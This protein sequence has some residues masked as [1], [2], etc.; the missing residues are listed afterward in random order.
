VRLPVRSRI[1]TSYFHS[2]PRERSLPAIAWRR[3]DA[4][5][6]AH[7]HGRQEGDRFSS[8]DVRQQRAGLCSRRPHRTATIGPASSPRQWFRSASEQE[9]QR[10]SSFE[11]LKRKPRQ[12]IALSVRSETV[13]VTDRDRVSTRPRGR[14][15]SDPGRACSPI[16]S[17]TVAC[18]GRSRGPS[19]ACAGTPTEA[20]LGSARRAASHP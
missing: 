20:I 14:P 4:C 1:N 11:A 5:A 19:D 17:G 16:S 2:Y 10:R 18:A 3:G 7:S 13:R 6:C 15:P 8:S 12:H 9:Q